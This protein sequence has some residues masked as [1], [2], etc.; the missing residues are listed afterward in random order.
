MH[1]Q[2]IQVHQE[3]ETGA[4]SLDDLMVFTENLVW[5]EI[6]FANLP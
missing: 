1:Y 4:R 6:N 5:E 3:K 2:E